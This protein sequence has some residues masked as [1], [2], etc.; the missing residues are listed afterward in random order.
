M[1]RSSSCLFVFL[2]ALLLGSCDSRYTYE[3]VVEFPDAEWSYAD[4]VTFAFEVPDTLSI[5]NLYLEAKHHVDFPNQNLYV[6]IHTTFPQGERL[7]EQVSLQ[8]SEG[9]FWIGNCRGDWCTARIP[10]QSGAYF[11]QKGEHQFKV[12][13]YMRRNPVTAIQ[14]LGLYIEDT[15]ETR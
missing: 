2:M 7:T 10:I 1:I 9:G 6:R 3:K 4:S 5:Y 15:G 14:S 12:E 8:L 13:Q 11:N